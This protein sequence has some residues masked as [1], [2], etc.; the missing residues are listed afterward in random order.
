M[1]DRV[2]ELGACLVPAGVELAAAAGEHGAAA[3]A[4]LREGRQRSR[5]AR[6]LECPHVLDPEAF[7]LAFE[8]LPQPQLLGLDR[9]PRQSALVDLVAAQARQQQ[10][11]AARQ[12]TVPESAS[13]AARV[14]KAS[15][16]VPRS[17]G[18]CSSTRSILG[19]AA[20]ARSSSGS[21]PSR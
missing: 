5:P 1:A 15:S 21:V 2:A 9:Q 6:K 4:G 20:M 16:V 19:V 11:G 3:M 17:R 14:A 10:G 8:R 18:S 12:R 7:A 13:A